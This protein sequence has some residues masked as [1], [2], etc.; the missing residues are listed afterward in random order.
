MQEC[1]YSFHDLGF[2]V[3]CQSRPEPVTSAGRALDEALDHADENTKDG[4]AEIGSD[5]CVRHYGG[6]I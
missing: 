2:H 3:R 1:D 6:G 4:Y 5:G